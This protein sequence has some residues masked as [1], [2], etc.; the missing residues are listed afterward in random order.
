MDDKS[1]QDLASKILIDV[2]NQDLRH[3]LKEK[4][5]DIEDLNE[6]IKNL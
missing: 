6:R 5:N 2:E 4:M 3:K 1:V